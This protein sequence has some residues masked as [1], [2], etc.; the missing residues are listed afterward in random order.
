M[1]GSDF[2]SAL[3]KE[4]T[5]LLHSLETQ[6][7]VTQV[8]SSSINDACSTETYL[9]FS[10]LYCIYE[11]LESRNST[12]VNVSDLQPVMEQLKTHE[13]L[14]LL[15]FLYRQHNNSQLYRQLHIER[16]S[17]VLLLSQWEP[18]EGMWWF[19]GLLHWQRLSPWVSLDL[20][21]PWNTLTQ[22]LGWL[23]W[24]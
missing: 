2:R 14:T 20:H 19:P 9:T 22:G 21:C 15:W 4:Q 10:F 16:G 3:S 24:H 13:Y 18:E 6:T 23:C 12:Y 5:F 11:T 1:W 8:I 7:V 17:L